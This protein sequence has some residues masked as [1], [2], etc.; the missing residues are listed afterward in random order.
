M[1]SEA[2]P[3]QARADRPWL[4]AGAAALAA[5]LVGSGIVATR[6]V[7]AE[8]HPASLALLRYAIGFACLLGP[9]ALA[10]RVRF[11]P[12][13]VVPIA[14]LG[15]VQFGV[16]IALLNYGLQFVPSGRGSLLFA[17]F[18]FLTMVLAALL[19]IERLSLAKSL[20]VGLTILG[21]GLALSP[22]LA[23]GPDAAVSWI[24]E[25]AILGSA[26]CGA[27]CSVFYRPYLQKYPTLQ[28]S[29]FAMFASVWFLAIPAGFEGFFSALPNISF[30]GWLAV[31]FIGVS[32]AVG[33]Y[34]WL[35]ALGHTTPTR[36]SIFLALSPITAAALGAVMLDEAVN[37]AFVAGLVCVVAGLW[38]AHRPQAGRNAA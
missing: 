25:V 11:A 36:V 5:F 28:V 2:A 27:L 30:G 14:V 4:A 38:V 12:R 3:A 29:T 20:G 13:D 22:K 1:A 16:L 37:A 24:G 32:S 23:S 18:P 8:T 9:A 21:V 6:F 7:I 35:W 17:T 10:G 19:S 15:I 31:V 33:Y 26:L 34:L